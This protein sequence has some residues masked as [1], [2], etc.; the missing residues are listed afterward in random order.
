MSRWTQG[1][2]MAALAAALSGCITVTAVPIRADVWRLET[3]V[4][5]SGVRISEAEMLRRAATLTIDNGYTHFLITPAD[6]VDHSDNL[7]RSVLYGR[8]Q[9]IALP[10]GG[11]PVGGPPSAKPV[12][13]KAVN[14]VMVRDG[15]PRY[16]G[17]YEAAKV[18]GWAW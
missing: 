14:V 1:L 18:L 9:V 7:V 2:L 4:Q 12:D 6:P 15:D 5:S 3:E 13:V 16:D 11:P 10:G 17:S 8:T